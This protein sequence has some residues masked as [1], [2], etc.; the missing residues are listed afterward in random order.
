MN[1]IY[2]ITLGAISFEGRSD[3]PT[4]E[5][6]VK[7]KDSDTI[8]DRGYLTPFREDIPSRYPEQKKDTGITE[9]AL[10]SHSIRTYSRV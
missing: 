8:V 2:I 1:N 7:E 6:L 9:Q 10:L 3:I 5:I 4:L